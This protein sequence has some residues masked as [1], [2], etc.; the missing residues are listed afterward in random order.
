MSSNSDND[1]RY[2]RVIRKMN[3]FV[4]E[5]CYV[6]ELRTHPTLGDVWTTEWY[7][8]LAQLAREQGWL[9]V[10]VETERP[11]W[12]FPDF[13]VIGPRCAAHRTGS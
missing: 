1:D 2:L 6:E 10:S 7:A 4:C 13:Q 9:M 12:F 3:T 11:S 8:E 5:L